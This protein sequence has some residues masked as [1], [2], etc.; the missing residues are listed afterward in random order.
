MIRSVKDLLH[1]TEFLDVKGEVADEN[2]NGIQV[3]IRV[4]SR[5]LEKMGELLGA[6]SLRT[7]TEVEAESYRNVS[8][9]GRDF[10]QLVDDQDNEIQILIVAKVIAW[11]V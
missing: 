9:G 5:Q 1:S 2:L 8:F 3:E 10:L 7:A 4:K 11:S 6:I